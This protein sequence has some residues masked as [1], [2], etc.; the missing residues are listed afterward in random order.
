MTKRTSLPQAIHPASPAAVVVGLAVGALALLAALPAWAAS[1]VAQPALADPAPLAPA[2][3]GDY[4]EAR[5]ADVYTGPCFANSEMDLV[6]K[7][8][9]V[10]WRV[11]QGAWQ[12]VPLDGLAVVA[13]VRS[14]ATLGD[15]FG[16]P[17]Q[18]KALIVVDQR[19]TPVQ[20]DALVALAH[21]LAGDLLSAVVG[22][23]SA[24]IEMALGSREGASNSAARKGASD[25]TVRDGG[26]DRAAGEDAS[27]GAALAA[28]SAAAAA[29]HAGQSTGGAGHHHLGAGLAVA[30]IS[31]EAHLR[32]GDWVELAT[33][34]IGPQDHLCGNEEVYYPPLAAG[35]SRVTAVPAVTLEHEFRGP[36]LGMVWSSPGKR[37]AFVGRFAR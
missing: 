24:P 17:L 6:G 9:V 20:R 26:S 30:G 29:R 36:G 15:P 27:D 25:S 3:S 35:H 32:A 21:S 37:S 2:I 4:M 1:Q 34:A 33:R 28:M 16:G 10:A 23:A 7:Q 19:A 18:A 5:T 12:G 14:A 11:R 22:V 13:A 8:A 31:G